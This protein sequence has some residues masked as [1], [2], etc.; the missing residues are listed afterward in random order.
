MA[1]IRIRQLESYL[2]RT[3]AACPACGYDLH[4]HQGGICPECGRRLS[5]VPGRQW[6][7]TTV[8]VG[9]A[10]GAGLH[11]AAVAVSLAFLLIDRSAQHAALRAIA[12][13]AP[14]LALHTFFLVKLIT[15][16]GKFQLRSKAFRLGAVAAA[17]L[18]LAAG[19]AF[20]KYVNT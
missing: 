1:S 2:E 5:V 7:L 8:I 9:L 14:F 15:Q 10:L 6:H 20:F 19:V 17:W 18:L 11:G 12:S 16:G 13:A 3:D 4:G